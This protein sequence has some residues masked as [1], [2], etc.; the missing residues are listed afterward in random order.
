MK[1]ILLSAAFVC[2]LTL[3]AQAQQ[4]PYQNKNLTPA[5]RAEDLL[6]RLTLD[7]KLG[8]MEHTSK[9]VE[10]LG[11]KP[12][13]WWNETLHGVGRN[14]LATVFPQCIGL[15][16]TF[17]NDLVYHVFDAASDEARAK[18]Y[19]ASQEGDY[20]IYKGLTF[21]TPNINI[22]RDPRWGRGQETYGEDPYLTELMGLAV[23]HGLQGE[24]RDGVDKLHACAK[25][26]AVHSGPEWNRHSF[27]IEKIDPRDLWETYLPAFKSLVQKGNVKEVMC[28]YNRVD[29]E[30]CCGNNRLLNQILRNE[31]GFKGVVT[32]DCWAVTDFFA[33]GHHETH[34]DAASASAAAVLSGTDIECGNVFT[35]NLGTAVERG[36]INVADI[37]TSIRRLLTA[38]FELGEMDE[39]SPWDDIPYSVVSSEKHQQLNLK[40]ALESIVLLQNKNNILPLSR[41]MKVAVIGAN[42]NDSVMLWGNYNGIP[43]KTYTVLDGVKQY[44]KSV[45][46]DPACDLTSTTIFKSLYNQCHS[47]KQAGFSATYWNNANFEGEPNNKNINY[48]TPIQ[49]TA[50]GGISFA[51]GLSRDTFSASYKSTFTSPK[52]ASV[53]IK[54][55][56]TGKVDVFVNGEQ[57]ATK[58][59]NSSK[60]Q[61][62]YTLE[63][64]AGQKY[65]IEVR[66]MIA[67]Y[68]GQ[69]G[70][71]LGVNE[72]MDT[73]ALIKKVSGADVVIY[74]GGI[75]PMLEGEE[76]PVSVEGFKGGDRTDIQL[77]KVQRQ[78]LADLKKAGKK[79]VF[80]N[81]SG[82][83]VGLTPET[84]SCDAIVQLFYAGQQ[85]GKALGQM[86]Y[87]DY[88]PAGRLPVT[89]YK[90]TLQ[91]PDFQE[92]SMK[93]RTYRYMKEAPQFCFGHGLSYT[94]F[95]YGEAQVS[96]DKIVIPVTNTGSRDG[97]EV[98]QLYVNRPSDT[99]GPVKTL[100]GFQRVNIPA[101]QT[102]QVEFPLNDETFC[103]WDKFSNT[104][105][106]LSG[107]F[108]LMYGG[109]SDSNF[110]K[111]VSVTRP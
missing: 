86:L 98:V 52:S 46:Y 83:A 110:L 77:P 64:K 94:T 100:R 82:S 15:A 60:K 24:P 1:N 37:D 20:A 21:W 53:D 101:G 28:A 14:G 70:L 61:T 65:D 31:W 103:W 58:G 102:V 80:V 72:P 8:L 18:H 106:A 81:C 104:M 55:S 85:G 99:E 3:S 73:Q 90:D 11:I 84:E 67:G 109:T 17:N 88:N 95:N 96:R 105:L 75:S 5:E 22:F 78:L 63:A 32:S 111:T 30:P 39:T 29:G 23:V 92:Y 108:K 36:D 13:T 33:A 44:A 57:V 69:F 35:K 50:D 68:N 2:S 9:A 40:A 47:G 41:K 42:A 26:F 91:I 97:D 93:G 62:L 10:R 45:I 7:E 48:T 38:R 16:A 19:K 12:Y 89:F 76:M 4:L 43:D 71:D 74:V 6:Q 79:V 54:A 87:G 56:Y 107:E 51:P 66:Y 34:A 49:L 27:D 59:G 25:H